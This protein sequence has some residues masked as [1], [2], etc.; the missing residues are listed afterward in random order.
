MAQ[1]ADGYTT[2]VDYPAFFY[3]EMTPVWL[4]CVARLQGFDAPDVARPFRYGELG[5]G[6]GTNLLVA[7]ACHPQAAF[8]GVDANERHLRVARDAAQAAGLRNVAFVHS[9]FVA[10]AA[11]RPAPFDFLATHGVWSWIAP[12]HRAGLLACVQAQLA[13]GGLFYLHYM[14][15]PGSTDLQELQQVLNLFAPHV[16]GDSARQLQMGL[17]LLRQLAERGMFA[18]RPGVLRHLQVLETKNPNH[19]AHEF[20]TDHWQP[21]HGVDVHRQ[22]GA[23]GLDYLGSADVFNNLDVALSIPGQLQAVLRQTQIP[24]LA[25]TLKDMARRSHQ[26]MDLF[27]RAARPLGQEAHA[28]QLGATVFQALPGAP[29]SGP[30]AFRT[31]IGPVE[32]PQALGNA[33]LQRLA[34][35]PASF[36]ELAQ[37]PAFAGQPGALVQVLQLMLMQELVHPALAPAGNGQSLTQWFARNGIAL[38]VLQDS[39]TAVRTGAAQHERNSHAH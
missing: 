11:S 36:A 14:C 23:L 29:A 1:R 12:Q 22:V 38:R 15:H 20:L 31:P 18:D 13:P 10:F 19:L 16:P 27:Q 30:V 17:K 8:V 39:G 33:L 3:K 35:G 6:V 4:A 24:A 2:D 37:L 34:A 7:A 26:R 32:V 9:G 5:C 25:E 21:Q 28:A